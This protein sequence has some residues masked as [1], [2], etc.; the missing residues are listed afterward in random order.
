MIAVGDKEKQNKMK[1][2]KIMAEKPQMLGIQPLKS[3]KVVRIAIYARVSTNQDI[4]LHSLEEQKKAFKTKIGQNPSWRLVD[5]YA[6]EGIS[7][8]SVK[9]RKEFLRMVQD[10]ENG[11]IDYIMTKSISRFARNTVE[12]LSYV[13]HLQS[14]GVQ[15]YFEKEGIDT[16]AAISE[17][18]LTVMAAFA[19]EESRSI[20]ENLKWGLRKRFSEGIGRWTNT[21]GYR[22]LDN[23]EIVIEPKEAKIVWTAF[24]MYQ[25]GITLPEIAKRLTICEIPSPRG[26]QAW[27]KTVLKYMLQNEKYMGDIRLQKWISIDHITHKSILND[28]MNVPSYY[29]QDEHAPIVDRH[30]FQQVQRIMELKS[31][32]GE[33]SRYPY[34]DTNF[35]CPLCGKK[36][37]PKMMQANT[38]KRI[39]GCFASE[40]CGEYALKSYLVDAALLQAY[41]SIEVGKEKLHTAAMEQMQK[42]K[43]ESPKMEKVYYYWLDD[44]LEKVEFEKNNIKIFWKCGLE[45]AVELKLRKSEEPHH[46]AELYKSFLVRKSEKTKILITNSEKDSREKKQMI[47]L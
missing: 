35:I 26:K 2:E 38:H 19:Q 28:A 21:Y 4:Q 7:G 45:S 6:D 29:V 24:K 34:F 37:L 12:C 17:M 9:N 47:Q 22:K 13:R 42:I 3:M 10:S 33:Y 30:T 5:I 25:H 46:V 16:A 15:I 44:L 27:S 43:R 1:V 11:K 32:H 8:T 39:I 14:I 31:P 23:G 20:S 18:I 40:G 36:M 41:N